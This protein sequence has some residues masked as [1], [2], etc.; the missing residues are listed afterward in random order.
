[1]AKKKSKR[2][3]KTSKRSSTKTTSA[4]AKIGQDL[5]NQFEGAIKDFR[6]QLGDLENKFEKS[7]KEITKQGSKT[8]K[9][10]TKR[11]KQAQKDFKKA[12]LLGKLKGSDLYETVTGFDTNKTSKRIQ[13]QATSTWKN[14]VEGI[15]A[16]LDLP[17]REEI[18]SLTKKIDQLTRK[19]RT[20]ENKG[21]SA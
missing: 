17:N 11:W 14:G 15:Q 18:D 21:A 19:V 3:T 10:F 13:K 9:E 7:L 8:Q 2:T 5:R 6:S 16:A 4:N 1:M 20:L 12:D